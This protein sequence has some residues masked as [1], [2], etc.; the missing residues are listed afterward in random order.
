MSIIKSASDH[1]LRMMNDLLDFSKLQA[2]KL[3]LEYTYFSLR[4]N[5]SEVY[6]LFR[7]QAANQK[8]MFFFHVDDDVPD[9]VFGDSYRLKQIIINL[10]NNSLKFTRQ[11]QISFSAENNKLFGKQVEIK[12]TVSDTGIGIEKDKLS[13]IFDEFVQADASFSRK[14]GGT[15]LGLSI[16]KKL[17]DLHKG[18]IEV[19]S[20]P[21]HGTTI[22]IFISYQIGD[23]SMLSTETP[24]FTTHDYLKGKKVLA[25]DDTDYNRLLLKKVA[26]QTTE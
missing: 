2:Q 15:G 16:V 18:R 17:L 1:L 14:Y 22:I 8:I 4:Q 5:F 12:I 20:E 3:K 13:G 21:S 24:E 6:H 25:V 7:Y 26:F 19:H 23:K 10:I 11:G 9:I